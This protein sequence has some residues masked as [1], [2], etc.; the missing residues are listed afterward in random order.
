MTSDK[1][2]AD[3]RRR[4]VESKAYS[5]LRRKVIGR[6]HE[7]YEPRLRTAGP[8]KRLALR[9]KRWL[10]IR[11]EF[12]KLAPERGCYL[13]EAHGENRVRVPDSES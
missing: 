4:V 12:D 1:I 7:Q 10:E 13:S 2:I 3:G 11:R 9:V 8:I 6:I 5:E